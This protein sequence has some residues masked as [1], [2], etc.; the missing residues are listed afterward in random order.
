MIIVSIFKT[1]QVLASTLNRVPA[2]RPA[3]HR[4]AEHPRGQ[5]LARRPVRVGPRRG[6]ELPGGL[7]AQ[8]L[9]RAQ[10]RRGVRHRHRLLYP[11]TGR[12]ADKDT[13]PS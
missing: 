6:A 10:P 8:D 3:R 4:Q 9:R 13:L 11:R 5:H 12:A 7:C 2:G 1:F